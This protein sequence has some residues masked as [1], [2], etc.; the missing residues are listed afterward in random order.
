MQVVNV[1]CENIRPRYQHLAEW[2]MN[3]NNVYIGRSGVVFITGNNGVK[4]RYPTKNSIWS[5]PYKIVD[6]NRDECLKKYR[7]YIILKIESEN[8]VPELLK[9]KNKTLGCWCSPEPCHGH[10]LQELIESYSK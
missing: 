7:E 6:D 10:I 5:N 8:L 1:R 3:S 2:C 4:F 9:L